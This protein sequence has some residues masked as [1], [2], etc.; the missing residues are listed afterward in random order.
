M[1]WP[2]YRPKHFGENT[3][4]TAHH[5]YKSSSVGYLYIFVN[6]EH[7]VESKY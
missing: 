2:E 4:N 6:I 7:F 3:V 1:R 5:I